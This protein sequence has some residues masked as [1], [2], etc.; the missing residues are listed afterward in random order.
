MN[1]THNAVYG[2]TLSRGALN[3][4]W[5]SANPDRA[6]GERF[7]LAYSPVWMLLMAVMMFTGWT[8]TFSDTALLIHGVLVAAPLFLVPAMLR[9]G[10]NPGGH[11]YNS[12]WFKAN[13]YIGL[14]GFFGN[15][16]GSEYFFD[17]LGMV[18]A[19]PHATTSLDA[20]LVGRSNQPVPVIMY[21]YT[22]AYFMTYHTTAIIVLRRV[23]TSGIPLTRLLFLPIVAVVGYFWAWMETRAMA[24]PLMATTFYYKNMAAM[25]A[26]GSMI[27]SLYFIGSFPIFYFLDEN[28]NK[29]WDVLKVAGA[30]LSA[31]MT[32]FYLLDAAAAWVGSL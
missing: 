15:Y 3:P 10:N 4:R 20:S 13:L 26:Y 2:T 5:F 17:V 31:S 23:M 32:V 30:G 8:S 22:H 12:Y 19:I 16:V 24:N 14:F 27:Y 11:W 29:P 1:T 25:L 28:G 18:Y 21:L 9:A 6:W 7:F